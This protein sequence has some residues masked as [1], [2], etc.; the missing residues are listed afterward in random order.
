M[1]RTR[2]VVVAA[3]SL[4]ALVVA[5]TGATDH[6]NGDSGWGTVQAADSGWG[7]APAPAD[8]ASGTSRV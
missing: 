3:L 4:T 6:T 1:S 5:L 7:R 8:A 2:A